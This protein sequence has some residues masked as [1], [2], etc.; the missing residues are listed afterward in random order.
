MDEI[1]AL[2]KVAMSRGRQLL[3][4]TVGMGLLAVALTKLDY[5]QYSNG[6]FAPFP[7]AVIALSVAGVAMLW[8]L[9]NWML[10]TAHLR[11]AATFSAR[12]SDLLSFSS[13]AEVTKLRQALEL[14]AAHSS[15]LAEL[16]VRDAPLIDAHLFRLFAAEETANAAKAKARRLQR[17][18]GQF[19]EMRNASAAHLEK[20]RLNSPA[21]RSDRLLKESQE[22]LQAIIDAAQAAWEKRYEEL[23]WWGKLT[24]DPPDLT[25]LQKQ[26]D[27]LRT[28]HRRL[29]ASGDVARS[30]AWFTAQ[31]ARLTEM[32]ITSEAAAAAS[33]TSTVRPDSD[34]TTIARSAVWLAAI[35]VPVSAWG[36]VAQTAD[37]YDTLRQV[38]GKYSDLTDFEIWLSALTMPSE[39]LQ[40]LASLV[41]GAYFEALVARETGAER[42]GSFNQADVDLDLHGVAYQLKATD[43]PAYV[44]GVPDD[45]TVIA[46][47]EVAAM[48]AAIDSG[49][50]NADLDRAMDLSF[51][52]SVLDVHDTA[53][54]AVLTGAGGLGLLASI[55]GINLAAER[56]QETGLLAE[57][58]IEGTG[59]AIKG[60]AKAMVD[61]AEFGYKVLQSRPS[62]FV[63]R[64]IAKAL[65]SLDH[66]L[67]GGDAP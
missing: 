44:L 10:A 57:A 27:D 22:K 49:I 41:K 43:S 66:K 25:P 48:T 33:I 11:S 45:I 36:D 46:T 40:G 19:A 12:L 53:L 2:R 64:G 7:G 30:E 29:L 39:S 1:S 51:G 17:L 6:N 16:L 26:A 61:S 60:T 59:E 31:K 42:I 13:S 58:V 5:L 14:R 52:G 37:I 21:I 15:V 50:S 63:G 4:L 38:N 28:A 9:V 47:S 35:S 24:T 32:L 34:D 54:D 23:S 20:Q 65:T 3:F 67:T 62:R 56:Y 18:T 8:G 55:R